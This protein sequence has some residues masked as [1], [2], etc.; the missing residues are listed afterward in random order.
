MSTPLTWWVSGEKGSCFVRE[1][2]LVVDRISAISTF[3]FGSLSPRLLILWHL[4]CR[5]R[6]KNNSRKNKV[7]SPTRVIE[8]EGDV[9]EERRQRYC[10]ASNSCAATENMAKCRMRNWMIWDGLDRL[11][12]E[13]ATRESSVCT[14]PRKDYPR[15]GNSSPNDSCKSKKKHARTSLDRPQIRKLITIFYVLFIFHSR[16]LTGYHRNSHDVGKSRLAKIISKISSTCCCRS[17]LCC[18][19][20]R[21]CRFFCAM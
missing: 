13:R 20:C 8:L 17:V 7:H 6:K 3:H 5:K 1:L 16:A 19:S 10:W 12:C 11:L 14:A 9:M 18:W 15:M 2:G 21:S 4:T